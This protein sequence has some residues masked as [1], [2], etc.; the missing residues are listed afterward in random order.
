MSMPE[1]EKKILLLVATARRRRAHVHASVMAS[2]TALQY[3]RALPFLTSL[4]FAVNDPARHHSCTPLG[5]SIVRGNYPV[6]K[7]LIR[8][9]ADPCDVADD[10]GHLPIELVHLRLQA[11]RH[12]PREC[13]PLKAM[14]RH[15]NEIGAVLPGPSKSP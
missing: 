14:L 1:L 12:Q 7:A 13:L 8:F 5:M 3:E 10:D 2:L 9:G 15:L 11:L 6:F 4:G